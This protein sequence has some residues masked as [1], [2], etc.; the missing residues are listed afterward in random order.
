MEFFPGFFT[1]G[2]LDGIQKMMIESECEP[3]QFKGRN[4]FM[5]MYNDI[6]WTKRG[7]KENC[8]ANALRVTEYARRV[9]QGRWSFLVPGSER[10]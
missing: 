8:I 9:T 3:E 6:D 7:H 4:I 2:I 10:K 5:S 1:L